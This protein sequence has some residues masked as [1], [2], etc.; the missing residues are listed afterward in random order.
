MHSPQASAS[1]TTVARR[2]LGARSEE[3]TSRN[4][5]W[6]FPGARCT[7]RAR[8]ATASFAR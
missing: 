4:L 2:L 5:L 8:A 3:G 1:N 6:G 7:T